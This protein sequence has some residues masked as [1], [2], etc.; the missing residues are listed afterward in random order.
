MKYTLKHVA[1]SDLKPKETILFD[2]NRK[3]VANMTLQAWDE[4]PH[5]AII[6]N[7]NVSKFM[8]ILKE[9]NN[10]RDSEKKITLN[11]ALLRI[12]VEGLKAA[13]H[14]NSHMEFNRWKVQGTLKIYDTI[15]VTMPI[16][17]P[18]G[19]MMSFNVRD[20]D[21]KSM[22]EI[23]D[24]INDIIRRGAKTNLKEVL[25]EV[26]LDN[27]IGYFRKGKILK[28]IGRMIGVTTGKHKLKAMSLKEK[29]E[30]LKIPESDRLTM[31]D[32]EQG[33]ITISNVGSLYKDWHGACT[34]L[35]VI[36]PQ[37]VAIGIG[38]AT[39]APVVDKNDKIIVERVL[40]ITIAF[41]HKALDAN[42]IM[43][44][45]ERLDEIFENP[46]VIKEWV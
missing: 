10:S 18:D 6:H 15:N 37:T 24:T 12:F 29:R 16:T 32:I 28:V 27:T 22:S 3:V 42:E 43:P 20:V 39:K 17:L 31:K 33:T 26:S 41:D 45:I 34:L 9:I 46:E 25:M 11:T 40:P 14:M 36:P 21:K 13:P 7:A 30:Y 35:E 8:D 5:A 1:M 23:G 2:M 38:S 44:F 19:S 4:I